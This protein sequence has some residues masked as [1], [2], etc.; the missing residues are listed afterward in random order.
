M[1]INVIRDSMKFQQRLT[2]FSIQ[3]NFTQKV[4]VPN[5]AQKHPMC[6]HNFDHVLFCACF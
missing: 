6:P 4:L 2:V 3:E 5:C 1:V